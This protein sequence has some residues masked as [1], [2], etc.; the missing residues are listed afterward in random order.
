MDELQRA[1]RRSVDRG[2][3]RHP[4]RHLV[5]HPLTAGGSLVWRVLKDIPKLDAAGLAAE[6]AYRA[7]V[8]I[9]PILV[10]SAAIFSLVAPLV[11]GPSARLHVEQVIIDNLPPSMASFVLPYVTS[12]FKTGQSNVLPLGLVL[13]LWTISS[14][15]T[16]V[17]KA[18]GRILQA[19][20]HRS[21]LN[22]H[23]TAL[24]LSAYLPVLFGGSLALVWFGEKIRHIAPSGISQF[25]TLWLASRVGG[26]LLLACVA[27]WILLRVSAPV[28][29]QGRA[30]AAGTLFTVAGFYGAS[31]VFALYASNFAHYQSAYGI[32]G[33]ALAL[34]VWLYVSAFVLL[35]GI[36]LIALIE[37]LPKAGRA[38]LDRAPGSG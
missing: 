35:G 18:A 24:V 20:D 38:G 34:L 15:I 27:I 10:F 1:R 37:G 22:R 36:E 17:M 28:G 21:F 25:Q 26:S 23:I 8:S 9:I 12:I 14:I 11:G 5:P 29:L 7:F 2:A 30:L 32:L 33:G 3:R 19:P 4:A 13:S 6:I 16:T 31:E